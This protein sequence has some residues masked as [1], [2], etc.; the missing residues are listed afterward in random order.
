MKLP[1]GRDRVALLLKRR[2][3]PLAEARDGLLA[4]VRL[5]G[6]RISPAGLVALAGLSAQHG[7][8]AIDLTNRANLQVRGLSTA[9]GPKFAAGL[10]AAGLA[11]E[12]PA[13]DRLR[14][15]LAS[16]LAGIAP[17]TLIDVDPLV[18]ALDKTLLTASNLDH[19]SPKFSFLFDGGDAA[20][21]AALAYDAG[22]LAEMS[23]NGPVFR[24][25]LA[26]S[27]TGMVL[28]P[29]AALNI[30][31]AAARLAA[32]KNARMADLLKSEGIDTV[33]SQ[34]GQGQLVPRAR[35]EATHRA[36]RGAPHGLLPDCGAVAIG[37]AGVSATA[38]VL[39]A[40]GRFAIDAT[41]GSIRVTPWRGLIIAGLADSAAPALLAL[42]A[43][44]GL[45]TAPSAVETVACVGA[46]ENVHR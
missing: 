21:V 7:N 30:A 31:L 44:L 46:Q 37:F 5:P 22:F 38:D 19:L 11:A 23:P 15:I 40:I 6:G 27:A 39:A 8:G 14:N 18:D 41:A 34:I 3:V 24:L 25:G 4:R 9:S 16:P 1:A 35:P 28:S 43:E 26:N 12:N 2:R 33:L 45:M 42:A 17:D 32:S 36:M 10:A 13:R 29:A 20:G